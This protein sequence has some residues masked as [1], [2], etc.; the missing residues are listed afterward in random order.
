M[1]V[2]TELMIDELFGELFSPYMYFQAYLYVHNI[3]HQPWVVYMEPLKSSH[4]PGL[5]K[6]R[7]W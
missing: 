2:I 4:S 1:I 5:C 7:A 6:T 3:T